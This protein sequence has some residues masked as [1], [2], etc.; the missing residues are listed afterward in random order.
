MI[1]EICMGH[2]EKLY[3]EHLRTTDSINKWNTIIFE[4]SF[5]LTY[6]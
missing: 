4:A 5:K 6:L 1:Y 2:K 3:N